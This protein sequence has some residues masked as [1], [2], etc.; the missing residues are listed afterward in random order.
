M[1][2]NAAHHGQNPELALPTVASN[3]TYITE[4][5]LQ[6]PANAI[7]RGR[8]RGGYNSQ[9]RPPRVH[10]SSSAHPA[11]SS[12]TSSCPLDTVSFRMDLR[13]PESRRHI[14]R[15]WWQTYYRF[16]AATRVQDVVTNNNRNRLQHGSPT[17][18]PRPH[19]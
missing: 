15:V 11:S 4:F 3:Y 2:T 12:S 18:G 7:T 17:H 14:T 19:L 16:T 8:T 13:R 6:S 10:A 5:V 1:A 9:S